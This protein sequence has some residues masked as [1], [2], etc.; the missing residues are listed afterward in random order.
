M[1]IILGLGDT[2][3]PY[4]YF[5]GVVAIC[6]LFSVINLLLYLDGTETKVTETAEQVIHDYFPNTSPLKQNPLEVKLFVQQYCSFDILSICSYYQFFVG[7]LQSDK[8]R[9]RVLEERLPTQ[10]A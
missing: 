9:E 1:K 7:Y 8:A 3:C 2:V 10:A 4:V 5:N 6:S